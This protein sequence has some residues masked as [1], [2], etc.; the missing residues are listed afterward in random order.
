MLGH[1][2]PKLKWADTCL[3]TI[4]DSHWPNTR[5]KNLGCFLISFHRNPFT[6][7]APHVLSESLC[8]ESHLSLGESAGGGRRERQRREDGAQVSGGEAVPQPELHHRRDRASTR[9]RKGRA[10]GLQ[11]NLRCQRN[12]S[13]FKFCFQCILS[14][15]AVGPPDQGPGKGHQA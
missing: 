5:V 15:F 9:G 12:E 7:P 6:L 14:L 11:V 8:R 13:F 10:I 2:T 4:S 1:V 3:V